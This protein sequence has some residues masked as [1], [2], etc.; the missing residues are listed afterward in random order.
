MFKQFFGQFIIH[1]IN[2]YLSIWVAT[3]VRG[4]SS[5]TDQC[6]WYFTT[7][8][9][10]LCPGLFLIWV[11]STITERLFIRFDFHSLIPGNYVYEKNEQIF[12]RK[13]DYFKQVLIW[14]LIL[15]VSKVLLILLYIPLIAPLST[16]ANWSLGFFSFSP[17]LRLFIVLIIVPVVVNVLLFWISDNLL[18][19]KYWT[20]EEETLR[21]SF[22]AHDR[23]E[24]I[25]QR[26]VSLNNSKNSLIRGTAK[27]ASDV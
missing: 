3:H 26:Y 27:I 16:F 18:K 23:N 11:F 24:E 13:C 7:F 5:H 4:R 21:K 2:V 12:I 1:W 8:I 6:A 20:P 9:I 22:Y 10:D 17:D 14:T 15:L 19:K 25:Q